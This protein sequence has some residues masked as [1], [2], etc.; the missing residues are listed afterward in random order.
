[1]TEAEADADGT[2]GTA[3][4]PFLPVP[5]APASILW[6]PVSVVTFLGRLPF[7]LGISFAYF[8]FLEWI[9]VGHAVKYCA[10]WL[11]LGIPGVWWV[12]LQVD[13][14]KRGYVETHPVGRQY[15]REN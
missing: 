4:A 9:P 10:L 12:D 7:L 14:V 3:I 5:P 1:M 8:C 15:G 2:V 6:T 11:M 13:G